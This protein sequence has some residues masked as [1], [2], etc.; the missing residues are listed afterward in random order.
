MLILVVFAI[1]LMIMDKQVETV[2]YIRGNF[3]TIL[4]PL[5]YLVSSPIK[6]L[7]QLRSAITLQ[8]NLVKENNNLKEQQLLL[9]AQVQRLLAMEKENNELK[10]LLRSSTQVQGKLLI[11]QLL[12]VDTDPFVHQV[13]LDKGSRDGVFIGQPV[14]DA[15]GVMGK[16][17]QVGPY[18]SRMLLINDPHSGIPAQDTRNGVRAIVMGDNFTGKLALVNVPQTFD[19][20]EGDVLVTSGLGSNFPEGYPIGRVIAVTKDPGLQFATITVEPSAH[21]DT[22]REVLLIW[23]NKKQ[24]QTV[25]QQGVNKPNA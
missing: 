21:L 13:I 4:L 16:V 20:K 2:S 6:A 22:A 11:A 15:N 17:V 12:E 7:D 10:A 18:S 8:S 24:D 14:L 9:K 25:I 23:P 19:I 1:G 5:Q 3:S